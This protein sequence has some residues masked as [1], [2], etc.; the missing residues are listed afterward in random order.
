MSLGVTAFRSFFGET[1]YCRPSNHTGAPVVSSLYGSCSSRSQKYRFI[2]PKSTF[3]MILDGTGCWPTPGMSEA[4]RRGN[5]TGA[6]FERREERVFCEVG[7]KRRIY[8]EEG[9]GREGG[10]AQ[11]EK[12]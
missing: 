2:L 1:S 8:E 3:A 12:K 5:K 11:S 4:A 6:C 7:V 9:G 10:T